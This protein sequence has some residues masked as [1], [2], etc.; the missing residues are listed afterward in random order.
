[1]TQSSTI[2]MDASRQPTGAGAA[3]AMEAATGEPDRTVASLGDDFTRRHIGPSS[4]DA[5]A[6]LD[7]LGVRSLDELIDRTVPQ[8]IR[9]KRPLVLDPALSEHEALTE[10]RRIADRNQVFRSY[11]G[12]GY[13]DTV[14]PPVIQRNIL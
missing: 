1:M 6:M 5:K 9:L 12:T 14:T 11:L 4:A 8:S 13:T 3:G 2:E 7:L 10:L